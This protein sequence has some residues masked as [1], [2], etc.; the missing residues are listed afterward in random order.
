VSKNP[1]RASALDNR[2]VWKVQPKAWELG[3][4]SKF[5]VLTNLVPIGTERSRYDGQAL[6]EACAQDGWKSQRMAYQEDY[7]DNYLE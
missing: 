5:Q 1:Q 3:Q 6:E 7:T 2:T 4:R